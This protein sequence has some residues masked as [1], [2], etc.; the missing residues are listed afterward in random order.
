LERTLLLVDDEEAI[1]AALERLLRPDEYKI[2]RAN[3]GMQG[4][5]V[6]SR[7][8]VDVVISDQRMPGM[9]G[10]EFLTQVKERY[11]Q[12][13]RI[14]LSGY[15]DIESV[16]AAIN[17]GAVYKFFCK[18]WDN[19][20][21]RADVMEAFVRYELLQEKE[22]LMQEIR[23]A[24]GALAQINQEL[25]AAVAG[26]DS[27]IER[28]THYDALTNLPNRVLF[29]DRIDQ[30]L[31]RA[32]RDQRMAAVLSLDL[33]R[34]KQVNDSFGQAVGDRM[35]YL[36]AER[37]NSQIRTCDTVARIAGDEFGIVLTDI[38]RSHDAGE[39][40]HKIL[41]SF[42]VHPLVVGDTEIFITLS[43]GISLYPLD[44]L[45]TDT[46]LK[47]A[48]AALFHSKHEGCNNFQYYASEMNA[49][50]L[51]YLKL[52]SE[53]RRALERDE[54]VLH[55]Q[56]QVDLSS[57]KIVGMEALLRWQSQERGLV[58]PGEFIPL[59]EETGL[60][61]SVGEW[62]LRTACQQ[63][64][65]W[66]EAGYEAIHVAVNLST[67]QFKQADFASV[68]LNI[69]AE[70]DLDPAM[71]HIELELTESLLMNNVAGTLDTL[72]RLHAS[73]MQMSIDDFGTGYS[74]LSYLKYF[75]ISRLKIDQSFVRDLTIVGNDQAIVAAIIA[76]GHGLGL[77][78][79]AEGVETMAQ[80]L[81][82]C[83]MGCDEMQGFLFSHP[84]TAA[85]MTELMR[86]DARLDSEA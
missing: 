41:E 64:K 38:N 79:I 19:V 46:L 6:L 54:F 57:G 78:V 24:N 85:A 26:K 34:F 11:P 58:A 49:A 32:H 36:V 4:L 40:A 60:I 52:E 47:N 69:L 55:Y 18:P 62:V 59:L 23:D 82:L 1:G 84:V 21:L 27:Q 14:V 42:A 45:T 28:I 77:N 13:I 67:L 56:P 83:K 29:V 80:R 17:Q 35:L 66:L 30:A 44:G 22:C 5:D 37:L 10:V 70:Y 33:D 15:A 75:P 81:Q 31:V 71:N 74:S 16:T 48:D 65:Q 25:A 7:H 72:N 61:L 73:G 86:S 9:S 51:Q 2:L 8:D 76:L 3:S 39:I 63:A 12:T 53:L 20:T 43:V 68:I 50:A